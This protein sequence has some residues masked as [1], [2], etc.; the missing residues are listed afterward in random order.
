LEGIKFEIYKKNGKKQKLNGS[1]GL[2]D[3][4]EKFFEF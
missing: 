4:G 2:T 3:L 1:G